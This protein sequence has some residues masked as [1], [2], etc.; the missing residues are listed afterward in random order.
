[1]KNTIPR[2]KVGKAFAQL[3][4]KIGRGEVEHLLAE[5]ESCEL[6]EDGEKIYFTDTR[7][8]TG[9]WAY[10]KAE[11]LAWLFSDEPLDPVKYVQDQEWIGLINSARE[12]ARSV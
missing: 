5:W 8:G 12:T 2:N 10:T 9:K 11:F 6:S 1:M 3:I 7:S 4:E